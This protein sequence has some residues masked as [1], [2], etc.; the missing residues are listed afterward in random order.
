MLHYLVSLSLSIGSELYHHQELVV[1][2]SFWTFNRTN[3][4]LK[5]IHTPSLTLCIFKEL[6]NP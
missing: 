1:M 5:S 3:L 2:V 6:R 4:Q